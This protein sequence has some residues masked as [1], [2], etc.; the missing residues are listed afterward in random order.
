[1]DFWTG[2]AHSGAPGTAGGVDWPNFADNASHVELV[3]P[4]STGS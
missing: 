1:M 3:V 2:H 4:L